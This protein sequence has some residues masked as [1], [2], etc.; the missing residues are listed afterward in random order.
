MGIETLFV[1]LEIG[2]FFTSTDTPGNVYR[3]EGLSFCKMIDWNL[4]DEIT[5]EFH[6][7]LDGVGYNIYATNLDVDD[8]FDV[9]IYHKD[10][11]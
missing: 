7:R 4:D 10:T 11:E 1:D 9:T 5:N 2:M 8:D 3:K 6:R